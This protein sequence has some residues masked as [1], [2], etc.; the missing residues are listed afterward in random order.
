M[1]AV[2]AL[3]QLA[4][5]LRLPASG[6]D[7]TA[8]SQASSTKEASNAESLAAEHTIVTGPRQ[9]AAADTASR[10]GRSCVGTGGSAFGSRRPGVDAKQTEGGD[11]Q[12]D[13]R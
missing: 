5:L 3:E 11:E 8:S 13:H 9:I 1:V 6:T 2:D 10:A 12:Q 4:A 7:T